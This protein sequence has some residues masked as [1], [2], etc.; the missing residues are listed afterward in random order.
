MVT[1][2]DVVDAGLLLPLVETNAGSRVRIVGTISGI[3]SQ[4]KKKKKNCF[5][6]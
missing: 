5:N 2:S 4:K 6:N 1:T 3:R